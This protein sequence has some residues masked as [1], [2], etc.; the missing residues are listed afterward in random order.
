[1]MMSETV[2]RSVS[3]FLSKYYN[4]RLAVFFPSTL[5]GYPIPFELVLKYTRADR[6]YPSRG[7]TSSQSLHTE[8]SSR[9]TRGRHTTTVPK[10]ISAWDCK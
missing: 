6:Y 7:T 5:D 4:R 9:R 3:V 2:I 1:M 10:P 8:H